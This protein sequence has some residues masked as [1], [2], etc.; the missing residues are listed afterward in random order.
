MIRSCLFAELSSLSLFGLSS[1]AHDRL[2]YIFSEGG[3]FPSAGM[4]D[5]I[6]RVRKWTARL[7]EMPARG[8]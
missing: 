6:C 1:A 3:S 5:N 8:G 7:E 2:E 4:A